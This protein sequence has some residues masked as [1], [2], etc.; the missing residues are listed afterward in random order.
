LHKTLKNQQF[1]FTHLENKIENSGVLREL[2]VGSA[3]LLRFVSDAIRAREEI[4]FEF[5]R[6]ISE[7]LELITELANHFSITREDA[8]HIEITTLLGMY[9]ESSNE[10]S[11]LHSDIKQGKDKYSESNSVWLPPLLLKPSDV[12]GFTMPKSITNFVGQLSITAPSIN[13]ENIGEDLNG[14]IVLIE[15]ADPGYDWIFA[16]DIAGL[17]TCYGGANSHMSVR[18]RE[19]D[20]PAGIGVGPEIYASLLNAEIIF[21]DCNSKRIEIVR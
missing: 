15:S 6:N 20:I 17:I 14:R 8:S 4:K 11:L 7:A 12:Y 5:S 16:Q 21:L 9:R 18:A 2:G 13:I 3:A 19:L 1:D 10:N